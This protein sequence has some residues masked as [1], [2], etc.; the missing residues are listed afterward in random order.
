MEYDLTIED[1]GDFLYA[2]IEADRISLHSAVEYI[3][4]VMQRTR[5][6]HFRKLLWIRRI[7][8]ESAG[9][10]FRMAASVIVNLVP[11]ELTVA[12]VDL[13][14]VGRD[15]AQIITQEAVAKNRNIRAF[16]DVDEAK[17]WLL[18]VD[19]LD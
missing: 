8:F 14:P 12:F 9:P 15:V 5:D 19:A 2:C 10:Q 11:R 13:S 7:R 6:G 17:R 4:R 3:N 18:D 16:R 1:H